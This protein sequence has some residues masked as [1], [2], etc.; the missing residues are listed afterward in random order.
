MKNR[1]PTDASDGKT[2]QE[3]AVALYI[4]SGTVRVHIHVILQKLGVNGKRDE[5]RLQCN[6]SSRRIVLPRF[7]SRWCSSQSVTYNTCG[8]RT[9]V[10]SFICVRSKL[11]LKSVW[12]G[13]TATLP[14]AFY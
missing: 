3:I 7:S 5:E 12:G 14:G 6:L 4:P 1:V 9:A 10:L 11:K 13:N 2:N 8:Y